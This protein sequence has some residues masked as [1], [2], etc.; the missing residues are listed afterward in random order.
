MRI[1]DLA[2]RATALLTGNSWFAVDNGTKVEKVSG[3]TIAQAAIESYNGSTLAGSQ[4]TVQS[5]LNALNSKSLGSDYKCIEKT[6]R[7][8]A[9]NVTFTYSGATGSRYVGILYIMQNGGAHS[10]YAV[11]FKQG[12][13]N[14]KSKIFGEDATVS[15]DSN[16]SITVGLQSWSHCSFFGIE[17]NGAFS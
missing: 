8:N 14:N 17:T 1:K 13:S 7:E 4:Q 5:A 10:I 12:T 11:G 2:T 3:S 15:I 16:G 6:T 9:G